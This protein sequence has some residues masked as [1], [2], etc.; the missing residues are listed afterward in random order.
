[1][2]LLKID[3]LRLQTKRRVHGFSLVEALIGA[4]LIAFCM[5][6]VL[7]M[8]LGGR[9]TTEFEVRYLQALTVAEA[10]SSELQRAAIAS[11]ASLPSEPD[12]L[13]LID[14]DGTQ[15]STYGLRLFQDRSSVALKFPGLADQLV[16]FRISVTLE[17]YNSIEENRAATVVV[18]FRLSAAESNWH[19][20]TLNSVIVSHSPI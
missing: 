10:V 1:M 15:V 8:V 19:R 14:I 16:N 3:S 4:I 7:T 17:P 20:L 12:M 9:K 18:F 11:L 2:S 6:A 13:P 5:G